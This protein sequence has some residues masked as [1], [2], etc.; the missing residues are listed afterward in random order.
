[1]DFKAIHDFKYFSIRQSNLERT[2]L[3]IA[4]MFNSAIEALCDLIETNEMILKYVK[5]QEQKEK[6]SEQRDLFSSY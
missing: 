3:L 5:Y 6:Q 1:M 4:E 2:L